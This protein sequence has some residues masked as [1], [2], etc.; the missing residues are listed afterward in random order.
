[1]VGAKKGLVALEHGVGKWS[2][3]VEVFAD[4]GQKTGVILIG[5]R[6]MRGGIGKAPE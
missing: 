6:H 4:E 3:C 5:Q 1:M 2:A